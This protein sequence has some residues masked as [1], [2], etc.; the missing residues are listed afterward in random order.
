MGPKHNLDHFKYLLGCFYIKGWSSS[1]HWHAG[2]KCNGIPI[3]T[4]PPCY[5]FQISTELSHWEAKF[6]ESWWS[7]S[8][9][10][11]C[12]VIITSLTIFLNNLVNG[13]MPTRLEF[14]SFICYIM[15]Q[16]HL[17]LFDC[18]NSF[19]NGNWGFGKLV[20]YTKWGSY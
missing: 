2:K 13:P 20:D 8:D 1:H 16:N 19:G 4:F 18:F 7:D 17:K 5:P 3:S 6:K 10:L 9:V 12:P 15:F 14:G 11:H